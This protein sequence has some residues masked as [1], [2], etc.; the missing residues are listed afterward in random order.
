MSTYLGQSKQKWKF[1]GSLITTIFSSIIK[2]TW[3][4]CYKVV[5][6]FYCADTRNIVVAWFRFLICLNFFTAFI[7]TNNTG[8]LVNS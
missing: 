6:L 7:C 8:S 1:L 4:N 2:M 3:L 5:Y